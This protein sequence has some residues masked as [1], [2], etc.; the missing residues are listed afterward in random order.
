LTSVFKINCRQLLLRLQHATRPC[1]AGLT[2]NFA[3]LKR[4]SG[5]VKLAHAAASRP[6][7]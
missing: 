3:R 2:L 1:V 6:A 5:Q 4:L 7:A